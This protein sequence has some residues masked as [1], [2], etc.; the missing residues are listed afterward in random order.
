MFVG[1]ISSMVGNGSVCRNVGSD[2]NKGSIVTGGSVSIVG[3]EM[4][5]TV[6]SS[7]HP[8]HTT[9]KINVANHLYPIIFR[10]RYALD[11]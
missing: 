9:H 6:I 10:I 8:T 11:E 4:A 1:S 5:G 2:V 3:M 7:A